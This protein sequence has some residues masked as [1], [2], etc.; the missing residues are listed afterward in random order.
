IHQFSWFDWAILIPYFTVL[1]ILSIYG[2]H[3]YDIIRTYF[4][5]RHKATTEPPR[6]FDQLPPV[7]IQLPLYNE[8]YVVE[9]LIDEVVKIEYPRELLQIQV[10][11]D[12][13]DDTAPFAEALVERYRN[14]GH[15]IEYRHRTNRHGFKAGALQEGLETAIGEVVA[16]FDADF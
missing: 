12:S 1:V 6:H 8:R 3:R 11:D 14:M 5:H 16:I 2:I 7:T 9:R 15:P 10:L 4:K 13:T